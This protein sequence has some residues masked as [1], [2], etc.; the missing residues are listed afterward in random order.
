M[1]KLILALC[2]LVPSLAVSQQVS[3]KVGGVQVIDGAL[4]LEEMGNGVPFWAKEGGVKLLL[5]V[6]GNLNLVSLDDDKSNVSITDDTGIDLLKPV[7]GKRTFGRGP[8]EMG[9]GK[10][11]DGKLMI[12]GVRAPR[13]PSAGCAALA[14][15]G[16]LALEVATGKKLLTAETEIKQGAKPFQ[17]VIFSITK[18]EAGKNFQGEAVVTVGVSMK[19]EVAGGYAGLRFLAP[20]GKPIK[21]TQRSSMTMGRTARTIEYELASNPGKCTLELATWQGSKTLQVPFDLKVATG[22]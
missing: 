12:V 20:G 16:T 5:A 8:F 21:A 9:Q 3:V 6:S 22:F 2:I 1:S 7:A 13:S 4:P 10:S 15:K 17:G 14:V 11:K 18:V 19:G